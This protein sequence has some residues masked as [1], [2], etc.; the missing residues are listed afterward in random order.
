MP[1]K[2][3][4]VHRYPPTRSMRHS[5][6]LDFTCA[7]RLRPRNRR[8]CVAHG[9]VVVSQNARECGHKGHGSSISKKFADLL[10]QCILP[11][12]HPW[13]FVYA[14]N[15]IRFLRVRRQSCDP[16]FSVGPVTVALAIATGQ[17]R[18]DTRHLVDRLDYVRRP[19]VA[20]EAVTLGVD[21]RRNMMRDLPR[22]V[23]QANSA[24]ERYGAEPD[25]TV[26]RALVERLPEAHVVPAVGA[27]AI[28]LFE[29]Q[30]LD[31]ALKI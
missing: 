15:S 4:Q 18:A 1:Q 24:V 22:I 10:Q 20:D 25:R 29:G 8:E 3:H 30:I 7:Y 23:T 2:Q 26:F 12:H 27:A 21:V 5:K 9:A 14:R 19:Q 11:L 16:D 6:T 17:G 28:R 13:R 31:A